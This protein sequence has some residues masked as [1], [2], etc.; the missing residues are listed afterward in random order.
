MIAAESGS[1]A[2]DG[3]GAALDAARK[4]YFGP[5][6]GGWSRKRVLVLGAGAGPLAEVLSAA[7]ADAVPHEPSIP[8]SGATRSDL[9]P[10]PEA[11]FHLTY[12]AALTAQ[13]VPAEALL[14]E[15]ARVLKHRGKLLYDAVNR[16]APARLLLLR[17]MRRM[18]HD[19]A[20]FLTPAETREMLQAV[21][22]EP[23]GLAGLGPRGVDRQGRPVFGPV[24]TRAVIYAGWAWAD[25]PGIY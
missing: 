25:K 19:P 12:C 8:E 7:G 5:I 20:R 17:V 3:F 16:T 24:P 14:A 23:R 2:G 15:G 9:L 4:S 22:L 6:V 13:P 10:F 21:G 11:S 1:M 18:H